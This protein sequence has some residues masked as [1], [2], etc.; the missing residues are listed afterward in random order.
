MHPKK[1]PDSITLSYELL[2]K[3]DSAAA[4]EIWTRFFDRLVSV[5]RREMQNANRRVADEE[6]VASVVLASLCSQAEKGQLPDILNRDD[7]WRMLLVRLRNEVIDHV[8]SNTRAKRGAGKVRGDSVWT[9][10]SGLDGLDGLEPTPQLLLEMEEELQLLLSKLPNAMMR[11][12]ANL[13]MQ[14][15]SNLEIANQL[16]VSERTIERKLVIIRECWNCPEQINE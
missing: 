14:G 4:V 3:G 9:Q 12:L 16:G 11:T 6:D 15:F 5:A 8:R 2:R 10:P 1:E 13:K 7:L